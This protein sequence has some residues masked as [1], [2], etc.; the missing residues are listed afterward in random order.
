MIRAR[1]PLLCCRRPH[2]LPPVPPKTK[3]DQHRRAA[4]TVTDGG[5][6]SRA[7]AEGEHTV[8]GWCEVCYFEAAS[9]SAIVINSVFLAMYDPIN[10]DS[11]HNELCDT[12]GKVLTLLF[13]V[14]L[15]CNIV[16]QGFWL[17]QGTF[18]RNGFWNWLDL[19]VVVT[20]MLDFVPGF[21]NQ[22]GVLR[23]ARLLRP[24]KAIGASKGLRQQV[25]VLTSPDMLLNI[26]NVVFLMLITFAVF[27][28]I[29][30]SVFGG[31]LHAQCYD[32]ATLALVDGDSVFPK[33]SHT[34]L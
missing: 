32:E 2:L 6:V 31:G 13:L 1:G 8:R 11:A 14:E 28:V 26:G 4:V 21:D 17:R 7:V 20:G 16:D 25:A 19:V 18:L 33:A 24:L 3:Q 9:L 34:M 23:T 29:G 22:L 12:A 10:P 30:V 15:L 5:E 27:A